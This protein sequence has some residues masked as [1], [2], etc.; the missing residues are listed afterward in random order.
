MDDWCNSIW[1]WGLTVLEYHCHKESHSRELYQL[2][3]R[4][5]YPAAD[6]TARPWLYPRI[7]R[8]KSCL[9]CS[10]GGSFQVAADPTRLAHGSG[11]DSN[12][13][14][15]QWLAQVV[16]VCTAAGG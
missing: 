8:L 2:P 10:N 4:E 6:P 9:G 13:V 3:N 1:Q 7:E 12:M 14:L 5:S 16:C 11:G 15:K